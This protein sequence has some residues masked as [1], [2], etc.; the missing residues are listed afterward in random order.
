MAGA[1]F[2]TFSAGEVL[3]ASE[4]NTFLMQQAVMVF[5]SA[6]ARDGVIT[7]PSEGMLCYLKDTNQVEKYTG[8][9]WV[10]IIDLDPY[11][12]AYPANASGSVA[13]GGTAELN[14]GTAQYHIL[15]LPTSGT[16]TIAFTG[17]ADSGKVQAWQVELVAGTA[18]P[19]EVVFPAA[20]SFSDEGYETITPDKSKVLSFLT[21]TNGTAIYGGTSFDAV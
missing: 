5:D 14:I 8:S 3:L 10:T 21:R 18:V 9:D 7:A 16:V 6:A 11:P 13:A 19:D 2:K 4:V 1:G 17:F 20:V 12:Q 15:E